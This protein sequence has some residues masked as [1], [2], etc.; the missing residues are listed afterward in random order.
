MSHKEAESPV[1][2]KLGQAVRNI[3]SRF[4]CGGKLELPPNGT[5]TVTYKTKQ[6]VIKDGPYSSTGLV[7]AEDTEVMWSSVEFPVASKAAMEKL[8]DACFVAS[9]GYL[10]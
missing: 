3:N 7:T 5:V 8:A 1:V 10:S 2:S 9:F 6:H 4:S